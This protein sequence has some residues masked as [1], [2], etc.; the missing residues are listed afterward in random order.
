MDAEV[1]LGKC[2]EE[3]EQCKFLGLQGDLANLQSIPYERLLCAVF[4]C[5]LI[6]IW[7]F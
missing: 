6:I 5:F 7:I 2:R 3:G 1:N 4:H